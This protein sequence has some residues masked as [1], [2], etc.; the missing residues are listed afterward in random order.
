MVWKTVATSSGPQ[1]VMAEPAEW[2]KRRRQESSR[3][4]ETSTM[5]HVIVK[6]VIFVWSCRHCWLCWA[7]RNDTWKNATALPQWGRSTFVKTTFSVT[8]SVWFSCW[9]MAYFRR[10]GSPVLELATYSC[11]WVKTGDR[12]QTPTVVSVCPCD[13]LMVVAKAVRTGNC[14]LAQ[15]KVKSPA[16]GMMTWMMQIYAGCIFCLKKK[17]TKSDRDICHIWA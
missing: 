1:V 14:R 4:C 5:D 16:S 15:S 2:E 6:A 7:M 13:L 17:Q 3:Q 9:C 10:A 11:P 8:F 12:S